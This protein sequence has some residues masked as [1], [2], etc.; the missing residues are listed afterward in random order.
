[1]KAQIA[2]L[3]ISINL[4]FFS[5]EGIVGGDGYVYSSEG[6]I[7]LD[8]VTVVI[9]LDEKVHNTTYSESNGFFRGSEFVGC[10]PNCPTVKLEF[11]KQ[12]YKSRILDFKKYFKETDQDM[13]LDSLIVILE[14]ID[15]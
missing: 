11:R 5:C 3:F 8:S 12:G 9:Y 14:K 15:P 7:P 13:Q 2:I 6:N 4:L 10:V 1:M